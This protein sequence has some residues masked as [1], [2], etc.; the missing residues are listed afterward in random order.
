MSI[1]REAFI[2]LM[3]NRVGEKDA[4]ALL[5]FALPYAAIAFGDS[6]GNISVGASKYGGDPDV[7]PGFEWP[8]RTTFRPAATERQVYPITFVAQINFAE[9]NA[10]LPTDGVWPQS[11]ML[12][13]FFDAL[14]CPNGTYDPRDVEGFRLYW[15]PE[16]TPLNRQPAPPKVPPIPCDESKFVLREQSITFRQ[17][18]SLPEGESLE[19]DAMA[20]AG[21]RSAAKQVLEL[22]Q[23]PFE[24]RTR[25]GGYPAT[26]QGGDVTAE[27]RSRA[28]G[29]FRVPN[30]PK[31]FERLGPTLPNSK[32]PWRLLLQ[33]DSS[34]DSEN[35]F[36]YEGAQFYVC[37]SDASIAN[38]TFSAGWWTSDED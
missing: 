5:R 21:L 14:R 11:G 31:G 20:R 13:F 17:G 22:M 35:A 34:A 33:F 23:P 3:R 29:N 28:E 27:C 24:S 25:L 8:H 26:E 19:A 37:V 9:A 36:G 30:S 10:Y 4:E 6:D 2:E 12:A 16:G 15:F 38:R 18:W 32:G 7:P 1:T